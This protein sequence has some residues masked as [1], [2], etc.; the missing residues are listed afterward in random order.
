[1]QSRNQREGRYAGK[2]HNKH[3]RSLPIN[4]K[5]GVKPC[6]YNAFDASIDMKNFDRNFEVWLRESENK[7]K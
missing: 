7:N 1:M 2:L 3:Y 6:F 4:M 5:E